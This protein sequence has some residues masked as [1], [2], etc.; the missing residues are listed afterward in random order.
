MSRDPVQ[1]PPSHLANCTRINRSRDHS[2]H[3]W[4]GRP[5]NIEDDGD[6]QNEEYGCNHRPH[7]PFAAILQES[8]CNDCQTWAVTLMR[9]RGAFDGTTMQ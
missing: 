3:P 6:E 7:D 8:G 9:N 4:R 5:V 1:L 2:H